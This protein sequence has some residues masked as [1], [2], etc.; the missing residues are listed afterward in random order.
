[1]K[2]PRDLQGIVERASP[3]SKLNLSVVRNGREKTVQVVAKP[4]PR[5]FA[6]ASTRSPRVQRGQNSRDSFEAEDLGI[7]VQDITREYLQ[8]L[9]LDDATG[10]VITHVDP[11]SV[12]AEQGLR[13]G[14]IIAKVGKRTVKNVDEFKQ[15]IEKESLKDGV[16]LLVRTRTGNRFVVLSDK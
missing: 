1:V 7:E 3:D 5:D 2:S 15:A 10:V 14:M 11:D 13:E 9:G 12:A 16:L 4:L 8:Q 6:V